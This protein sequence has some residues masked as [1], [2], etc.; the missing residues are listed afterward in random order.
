MVN[1]MNRE[2]SVP[3]SARSTGDKWFDIVVT[4]LLLLVTL[5]ILY[6]IYFVVI[7][8]L[9]DPV[10]VFQGKISIFIRGFTTE[11]YQLAFKDSR[12]PMSYLNTIKYTALGT[13]INIILS[14]A[15]AYPLSRRGL[16]GKG[17]FMAMI[18]FTMFFS[19]G[20]IPTYIFINS[21][22]LIDSLWV[23]VLPNAISVYNVIIMRTFFMN[24]IPGE[25]EEAACV[26]GASHMRTLVS[27]V[28]PLSKPVMAVMVLYYAVAHWNSYYNGLLYLRSE[29]KY[30][31][32]LVLRQILILSEVSEES[33][34]NVMDT[35]N[36]Q[37]LSETMKYA[38]IVI[39]TGPILILYP[40]LQ[41]Y[42]VQGVMIGS[43]KG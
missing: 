2:Q 38:L 27:I 14:T 7:A 10:R 11:A 13:C 31:L 15:A 33:F 40:F 39:A 35:G 3:R 43:V 30:P 41:K 36:R 17:A 42:F 8:S 32:Q 29:S 23:M 6:P 28:L 37:L 24:S 26:D 19:G 9:S 16:K 22:G 20:M 25:L 34:S 1:K 4:V 5:I 18:T 12:I 21:Y